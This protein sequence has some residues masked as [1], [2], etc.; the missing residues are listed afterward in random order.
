[1]QPG[2]KLINMPPLPTFWSSRLLPQPPKDLKMGWST[3][4]KRDALSFFQGIKK[5]SCASWIWPCIAA[6]YVSSQKQKESWPPSWIASL[7]P[8][9]CWTWLSHQNCYL[10]AWS[11][12]AVPMCLNRTLHAFLKPLRVL[13]GN[14]LEGGNAC[15]RSQK[16][17]WKQSVERQAH[18]ELWHECAFIQPSLWVH[19]RNSLEWGNVNVYAL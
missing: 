5:Q 7:F 9:A 8:G 6:L 14:S 13:G 10:P 1:M 19:R 12:V 17:K 15:A 18:G 2:R 16:Q 4:D 11:G 3:P